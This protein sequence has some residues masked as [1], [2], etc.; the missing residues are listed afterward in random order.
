MK[1]RIVLAVITI[2]ISVAVGFLIGRGSV[3][4]KESVK[5]VKGKTTTDTITT[6]RL[7]PYAVSTPSD[8]VIP[9]KPDTFYKEGKPIYIA[10]VVDTA[11]LIAD[12][13]KENKYN[14]SL[15]DNETEGS[16]SVEANV[17]YNALKFLSYTYT[18][19]QKI[20]TKEK[21]KMLTP[22]IS[23]R[24]GTRGDAGVGAGC[25]YHSIGVEAMYCSDTKVKWVEIGAK[26]KF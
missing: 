19:I 5:Y 15:F 11:K 21:I 13:V 4:I 20:S 12:Y 10:S 25:F 1:N 18:P 14:V 3:K 8:P 22:F 16:C 26:I 7:V 2:V 17:Q 23:G 24:Y 6:E 9:M